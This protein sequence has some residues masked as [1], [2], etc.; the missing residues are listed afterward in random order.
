MLVLKT[1][2]STEN[3]RGLE[4]LRDRWYIALALEGRITAVNRN[5]YVTKEQ[6]R[7]DA[8]RIRQFLGVKLSDGSE[9]GVYHL[10]QSGRK[11]EAITLACRELGMSAGQARDFVE[12]VARRNTRSTET[13]PSA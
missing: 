3:V 13:P 11:I 6:A 9:E 4:V 7:C 12:H 10:V 1:F 2:D 5:L 8:E